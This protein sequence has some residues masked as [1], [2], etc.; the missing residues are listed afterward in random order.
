MARSVDF[1][2]SLKSREGNS[3]EWVITNHSPTKFGKTRMISVNFPQTDFP[4]KISFFVRLN[5]YDTDS[6]IGN[7]GCLLS[8]SDDR[9][10]NFLDTI[11]ISCDGRN[12]GNV[13]CYLHPSGT[14]KTLN[15]FVV[16]IYVETNLET[17]LLHH[18]STQPTTDH[19]WESG[20]GL[21]FHILNATE[22]CVPVTFNN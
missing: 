13:C 9:N 22:I 17:V 4:F 3:R 10:S 20:K 16:M 2:V 14:G 1:G 19:K 11:K 6:P 21:P 8:T 18:F 12:Q 7:N 5:L 15:R